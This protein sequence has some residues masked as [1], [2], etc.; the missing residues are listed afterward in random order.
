M[1]NERSKTQ[2][3]QPSAYAIII[4]SESVFFSVSV[5]LSFRLSLGI[6]IWIY[7]AVFL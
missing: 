2:L 1:S 3:L 4:L 5:S 6:S 7:V